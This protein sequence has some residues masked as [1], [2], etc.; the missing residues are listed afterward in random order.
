[1]NPFES[2]FNMCAGK[3]AAFILTG[4]GLGSWLYSI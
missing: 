2:F 3:A 4:N 1:M